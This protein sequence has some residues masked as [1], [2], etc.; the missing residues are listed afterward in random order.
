MKGSS[1]RYAGW[2]L[3]EQLSAVEGQSKLAETE[4]A[5]P[6]IFA[7]EVAL[8]RLWG[9]WGIVPTTI[10]GHSA[11]EVAA[12]HIAGVLSLE[13]ALR[14]VVARGRLMQAATGHGRM[15]AVHLPPSI[16]AK[17]LAPYGT[18]LSIAAINS[19]E[20]TVISGDPS[21]VEELLRS[22][23][24]RG[25]GC[26]LLPVNYAF[27]SAQM[28][29]YSEELVRVLGSVETHQEKIPIISTV[30]G[31]VSRG[32]EFDAAYWGRN[33]RRT[34]LFSAAVQAAK[35]L[36]LRT[37]LEVGPHPVL[38]SSVGECMGG[39]KP[40][41]LIPSMRR[42]QEELPV[43]LSSLGTLYAAGYP[44]AWESVYSRHAPPVSLP[45]YPYQRQRF[46]IETRS[47]QRKNTLHPL[48]G[49]RLRSPSIHGAVFESQIDLR[50]LP[51]LTDHK[52]EGRLLVPMT[53]FLEMAQRAVC[54]ASG[55]SRTLADV[56]ILEPLEVQEDAICTV[57][58]IVENDDVR[59][60]SLHNDEW[61]LHVTA[62]VIESASESVPRV[63][64]DAVLA[65]SGPHYARLANFGMEF[66]P[67]FRTVEGLYTGPGQAW[68]R[69][70]LQD[71]E[72]REAARYLFHPALLDGCLQ[73]V[74][75][76][77]SETLEGLYLPFSLDRLEIQPELPSK[78][79]VWAQAS[80]RPS[81]NPDLVTA[82]IAIRDDAGALL[83]R[84]SG[85]HLKRRNAARSKTYVLEWRRATTDRPEPTGSG[86]WLILSDNH[87]AATAL[88]N[89]LA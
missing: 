7:I 43:I 6:A 73:A 57:Q 63:L 1:S 56:T 10:I 84:L 34:V 66:G 28:R 41:N 37:F 36:E 20:S 33:I 17:D 81:T 79:T 86:T 26:R 48:L 76:A 58:A 64:P 5:Q 2:S 65:S 40:D 14:V 80:L 75:A 25:I 74:V 68:A 50:S 78:D 11:G 70:R 62:R 39:G 19:P 3:I 22:W 8:A 77:T 45:A 67:A 24:G 32:E 61:K 18:R 53:A 15:A 54:E 55:R 38:L 44:V 59:I 87:A 89:A 71:A 69:V 16:V 31:R 46:W 35:E 30:W 88:A 13:E 27:H 12:A 4:Y 72:K 83:A 60:F 82:D 21:A 51:Y 49:A 23:L 29:T 85:F 47:S 52:I 42:N 9:S